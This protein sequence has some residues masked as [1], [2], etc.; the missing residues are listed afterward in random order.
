[1]TRSKSPTPSTSSASQDGQTDT[2]NSRPNKMHRTL[3][4]NALPATKVD[5]S[6]KVPHTRR[7][8]KS[9]TCSSFL[10]QS[11]QQGDVE[12][13][14]SIG[15]DLLLEVKKMQGLL[16]EKNDSLT[17]LSLE[18]VDAQQEF[19]Q[20]KN[21]LKQCSEALE[22]GKE[23]IWNLELEKQDLVQQV[24]DLHQ[25]VNRNVADQAKLTSQESE[26]KQELELLKQ[27]QV[28]WQETMEQS[29]QDKVDLAITRRKLA[30][31]QRQVS[32]NKAM[33]DASRVS[34]AGGFQPPYQ[35][36]TFRFSL[37]PDPQLNLSHLAPPHSLPS[38]SPSATPTS[39]TT[40]TTTTAAAAVTTITGAVAATRASTST[41]TAT[42]TISPSSVTPSSFPTTTTKNVRQQQRQQ[43]DEF[44][45]INA[46]LQT[47]LQKANSTIQAL[48]R[49]LEDEQK[50][51]A[52]MEILWRDAQE[53][54][55]NKTGDDEN[56]PT[57]PPPASSLSSSSSSL[58]NEDR[59]HGIDHMPLSELN[60]L[61]QS[62]HQ[63]PSQLNKRKF[64][65]EARN[66]RQKCLSLGDE[67][68]LAGPGGIF[69]QFSTMDLDSEQ[70]TT[71]VVFEATKISPPPQLPPLSSATNKWLSE[72]LTNQT[73]LDDILACD[74]MVDRPVSPT[75]TIS[76]HINHENSDRNDHLTKAN[77]SS[78]SIDQSNINNKKIESSNDNESI[79][80]HVADNHNKEISRSNSKQIYGSILATESYIYQA[81]PSPPSS[82]N[83]EK[84][85]S[86]NNTAPEMERNNIEGPPNQQLTNN[87][88]NSDGKRCIRALTRTMIGDWMWKYTRKVVG[89]GISENRHKRFFWLHPYSKTLYWSTQEPGVDGCEYNTKCVMIESFMVIDDGDVT[90]FYI[91]TS[92]RGIKIQ[93][94]DESTHREWFKSLKYLLIDAPP[95]LSPIPPQHQ[96]PS[97]DSDTKKTK[98]S[99]K[100]NQQRLTKL[101]R[102]HPPNMTTTRGIRSVA[103]L[104]P[105]CQHAFATMSAISPSRQASHQLD[106]TLSALAAV[107]SSP[108]G[109]THSLPPRQ[110]DH[111]P[112]PSSPPRL[113]STP[114]DVSCK[115]GTDNNRFGSLTPAFMKLATSRRRS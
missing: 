57:L 113:L 52:E 67:L 40:T 82:Q 111:S 37:P 69:P 14:T 5:L 36:D 107:T 38:I 72:T 100:M 68:S 112:P 15:H 60:E 10:S 114:L 53:V 26:L 89:N 47:S 98:H 66:N 51:R 78:S 8:T 27:Q 35:T 94:T 58:L 71:D 19:E 24:D 90:S 17:A 101:L 61:H 76:H 79:S 86:S 49:S 102:Y 106:S 81:S 92:G 64:N 18:K 9:K 54:I 44:I 6:N 39:T 109:S 3:S 97:V 85:T 62:D 22:L 93:C 13:A 88:S 65:K 28:S 91:Q 30:A 87:N 63:A 34:F 23:Q 16:Q 20:L 96:Q 83:E 77:C 21:Q 103:R 115:I 50:K 84:D 42:A 48:E 33:V 73:N 74:I 99:L 95:M 4:S 45:A 11:Q 104:R 59:Q 108:N 105:D 29:N 110:T 43:Q 55:E 70:T 56:I 2:K 12:L 32:S 80:T 75:A 1:M 46:E 25:Q 41:A 7:V 31:L